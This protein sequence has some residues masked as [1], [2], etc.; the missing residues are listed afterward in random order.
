MSRR[1]GGRVHSE[2]INAMTE[3]NPGFI[4]N[5]RTYQWEKDP[6][7]KGDSQGYQDNQMYGLTDQ[8]K[9]NALAGR[10]LDWSKKVTTGMTPYKK[11]KVTQVASQGKLMSNRATTNN[12]RIRKKQGKRSLRVRSRFVGGMQGAT[13]GN[14]NNLG[15]S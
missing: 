11:R 9:A 10:P 2:I 8:E 4:W 13:G 6:N 3:K 1:G 12:L 7:Y 15:M 5:S 14:T